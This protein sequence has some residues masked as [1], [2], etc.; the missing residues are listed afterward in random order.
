MQ[1]NPNLWPI[2]PIW[3]QDLPIVFEMLGLDEFRRWLATL[4]VGPGGVLVRADDSTEHS[5]CFDA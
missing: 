5:D 3:P 1:D 4:A 2:P